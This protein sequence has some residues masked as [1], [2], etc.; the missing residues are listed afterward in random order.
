MTD[1]I[2]QGRTGDTTYYLLPAARLPLLMPLARLGVPAPILDVLDAP[3]RVIVE[4]GYDRGVNPGEPTPA[5]VAD[6]A[7]PVTKVRNLLAA[8][9]TGL[10]DGLQDAGFGRPLGTTPAGTFGVGVVTP[11]T[12]PPS[13]PAPA[14]RRPSARPDG[15]AGPK[16]RTRPGLGRPPHGYRGA[17]GQVDHRN[18]VGHGHSGRSR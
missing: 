16:P 14:V 6:R 13:A 1:A 17:H 12:A 7:D 15:A 4:W 18:L 3:L 10:D 9:P 5:S 11:Q 2:N 8:I